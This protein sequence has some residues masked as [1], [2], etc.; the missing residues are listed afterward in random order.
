MVPV[1]LAARQLVAAPQTAP[2]DPSPAPGIVAADPDPG[3]ETTEQARRHFQSGIKLYRDGNYSGALAEFE[4]AYALKPGASSLQNI[5]LALK[6]LFR[7]AEAADTLRALLERHGD[8]LSEP[9]R[10]AVDRAIQ[11]LS[12]LVGSIVVRV[13]PPEARVSVDGRP[14]DAAELQ[15]GIRLNVGEHTLV[16]EAPGYG[17][18]KKTVRVA[19]GQDR[20]PVELDLRATHGFIEVSTK[21]PEAAIAIDNTSKSYHSYKGPLT[22]GRHFVQVYKP[23]FATFERVVNIELGKTTHVAAALAPSDDAEADEPVEPEEVGKDGA[24]KHVRGWY[25]LGALSFISLDDAPSRLDIEDVDSRTGASLGV[26]AGY[27][28][29]TPVGAELVLDAGRHDVEDAPDTVLSRDCSCDAVRDY[30]LE[31][32]RVGGN[33]RFLSSGKKLRFT[34]TL[35][36]GAV[37]HKV[38]LQAVEEPR[39]DKVEVQAVDPYFMAEVGAQY[40]WGRLLLEAN[41]MAFIDGATNL[42]GRVRDGDPVFDDEG[43]GLP[44]IGVGLR[45]GW[46]EWKP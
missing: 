27:R 13:S 23:G 22:P 10:Q 1:L 11:E 35:G 40:N 14:L 43:G 6:G 28:L 45:G 44:M 8:T 4:A 2:P 21:D 20:V 30:S 37:R 31:S 24:P 7:Y 41:V 26:R 46:S 12:S 9:A 38:V 17:T 42:R 16:A 15:G 36:I 5:A 34:S 3:D 39:A 32:L 19:G 33:V 18:A 25:V 29:W